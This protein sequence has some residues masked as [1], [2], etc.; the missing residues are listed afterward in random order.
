[1]KRNIKFIALLVLSIVV[2]AVGVL[3]VGNVGF[4]DSN[5]GLEIVEIILGIGGLIVALRR[6]D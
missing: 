5:V 1:M 4:F 6:P 2:L 3:G